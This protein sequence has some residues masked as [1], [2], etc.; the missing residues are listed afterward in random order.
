MAF[1]AGGRITHALVAVEMS[2]LCNLKSWRTAWPRSDDRITHQRVLVWFVYCTE[3]D[4]LSVAGEDGVVLAV[5][6]AGCN[7]TYQFVSAGVSEM[8][9]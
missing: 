6:L 3:F 5:Q 2:V 9:L 8:G 4:T 7:N 1:A